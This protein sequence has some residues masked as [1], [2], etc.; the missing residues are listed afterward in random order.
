MMA[1]VIVSPEAEAQIRA[2]DAWWRQNRLAAPELFLQEL[3]EAFGTLAAVPWAGR[4]APHPEVRGLRRLLLRASRYHVYYAA[5]EQ[6]VL[7][8]AV[9]SAVRGAGP[10]LQDLT[11]P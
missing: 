4:T 8:L 1:D 3:A 10:N 7:V 2:I 11:G 9:W 6:T 5:G